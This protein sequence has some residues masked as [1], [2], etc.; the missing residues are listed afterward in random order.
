M[1]IG[2]VLV[3]RRLLLPVIAAMLFSTIQPATS[4]GSVASTDAG[5][6]APLLVELRENYGVTGLIVGIQAGDSPPVIVA[7]GESLPG[8][9]A[10]ADMHFRIG[11][12][13]ITTLTTILLQLVDEGV[14]SLD[15]PLATWFPDYPHADAITVGML[16][17]SRS[18]YRDYVRDDGFIE[19][20]YDDVFRIWTPDELT[21]ITFSMGMAFDPGEGF[22]YSHA[23]F[24]ILGQVL[25]AITGDSLRSLVQLRVVSPLGLS[26]LHY[27]E[28]AALSAPV[29]HA[30]TDERGAFENATYWSPSW[31]SHTGFFTS[32]M[33]DMLALMRALGSGALL[34]ESGFETLT[35]PISVGDSFNRPDFYY[36]Y[37]VLV[38]HPWI[39]QSFSFGG[40][41]GI[42]T[43]LPGYLAGQDLTIGVVTTLG[44]D[45]ENGHAKDI[46]ED[47]KGLLGIPPA[48]P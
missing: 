32:D 35:A 20:F 24:I 26:A 28:D 42:A 23:N 39:S 33:A 34:S 1:R 4:E 43:Y 15:T 13:S 14:V 44:P 19:A 22:Q 30:Y 18:G 31:T 16:A 5:G 45:L 11:A 17:A 12:L 38:N 25:E 37:G 3:S 29:L 41:D 27:R 2:H 46:L 8:A 36:A 9:S 47:V 7:A 21:A 48:D 6:L 10:S 40:Y